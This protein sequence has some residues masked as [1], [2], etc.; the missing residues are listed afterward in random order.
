[1]SF[2]LYLNGKVHK[3]GTLIE[4]LA[5]CKENSLALNNVEIKSA[6]SFGE[7]FQYEATL[8]QKRIE[9]LI[10]NFGKEIDAKKLEQIHIERIF[11]IFL[12]NSAPLNCTSEIPA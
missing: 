1:M 2:V 5:Y 4:I 7:E 11:G 6:I 8:D 10:R 3:Q 9:Y 12:S